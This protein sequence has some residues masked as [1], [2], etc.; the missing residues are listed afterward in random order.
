MR[1]PYLLMLAA[2]L[3]LCCAMPGWPQKGGG[4]AMAR[5]PREMPGA[6]PRARTPI[7]EFER[8]PP[9]QQRRELARLPAAQRKRIEDQ[10]RKFNQLPPEQRQTL[11]NLYSR[12]HQLPAYEQESVHHAIDRFS[13]LS[14]DRQRAIRG[15]LRGLAPLS[16]QD[17]AARLKSGDFKHTFSRREQGIVRDMV[18]LLPDAAVSK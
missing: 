2:V 12:L 11:N 18:P 1:R 6:E 5:A 8:M 17:R 13:K 10:L 15:E 16:E 3:F 7:E 9:E 4:H 14:M